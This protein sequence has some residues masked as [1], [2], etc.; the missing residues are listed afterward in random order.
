[1][2]LTVVTGTVVS[3]NIF[4]FVILGHLF[5][6]HRTLMIAAITIIV[7]TGI[8]LRGFGLDHLKANMPF[9]IQIGIIG[10]IYF[11]MFFFVNNSMI[12]LNQEETNATSK[13]LQ[14]L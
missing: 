1:M 11:I 3:G 13:S 9:V 4:N 6:R 10:S 7:M 12:L 14:Q 2:H 5:P 8:I